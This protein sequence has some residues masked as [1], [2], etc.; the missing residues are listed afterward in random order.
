[1]ISFMLNNTEG[2]TF[3]SL[4]VLDLNDKFR[5]LHICFL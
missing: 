2:G 5:I 4:L 3:I 1:M